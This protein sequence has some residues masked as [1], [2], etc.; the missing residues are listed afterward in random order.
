MAGTCVYVL[1]GIAGSESCVVCVALKM[2]VGGNGHQVAVSLL[3][4][5]HGAKDWVV[6]VHAVS[7]LCVI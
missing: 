7:F 3:N 1:N 4:R 5:L 6:R 2:A